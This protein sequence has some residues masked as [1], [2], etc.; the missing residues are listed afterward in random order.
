MVL[1][2]TQTHSHAHQ[3]GTCRIG[4]GVVRKIEIGTEIILGR[5]NGSV[6]GFREWR[7][8]TDGGGATRCTRTSRGCGG[9][10]ATSSSIVTRTFTNDIRLHGR[11]SLLAVKLEVES[12]GI[13]E[14]SA[15]LVLSPE[16]RGGRLTVVALNLLSRSVIAFDRGVNSSRCPTG[17]PRGRIGGIRPQTLGS[18][19]LV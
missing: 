14:S 13:A 16:G 17:R 4:R 6:G 18:G 19:P 8:S 5:W 3:V 1:A 11:R 7:V 2:G 10:G 9:A 15:F 12:A